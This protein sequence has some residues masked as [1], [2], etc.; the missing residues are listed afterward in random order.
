[1]GDGCSTKRR[2]RKN[3]TTHRSKTGDRESVAWRGKAVA[4]IEQSRE[5]SKQALEIAFS[6]AFFCA[7]QME[8][9]S[10]AINVTLTQR[11]L[12]DLLAIGLLG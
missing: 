8:Y 5:K 11:D 12:T 10:R 3:V 9:V 4:S 1:M 2:G 6:R 7:V